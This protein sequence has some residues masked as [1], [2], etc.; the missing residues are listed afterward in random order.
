MRS[1]NK[2]MTLV[3]LLRTLSMPTSIC[4]LI[5]PGRFPL[6]LL[7]PCRVFVAVV[8]TATSFLCAVVAEPPS[9]F[10][11]SIY[12]FLFSIISC[13]VCVVRGRDARD[14]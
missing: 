10:Y 3:N 11:T 8:A 2:K 6:L 9:C 7:L 1:I 4:H 14:D 12:W 13:A 5:M